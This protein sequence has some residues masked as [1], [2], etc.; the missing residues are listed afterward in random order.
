MR[1]WWA[2][3]LWWVLG[4]VCWAAGGSPPVG[5]SAV[6]PD[7]VAYR[8]RLPPGGTPVLPARDLLSA[9]ERAF[10]ATLPELR[11]GLNLPDNRPYEV[12][13]ADGEVSGVQVELLTHLAQSLGLRLRPV[14][15]PS[16]PAALAALR[17]RQV[18]LM[19]TLGYEP[20]R[21][22]YLRYTLGTAPNPGAVIGRA[23]DARL[24]TDPDLNQ[25]R[26]AI[27]RGY[28]ARHHVQRVWPEAVIV[29][30]PDTAAALRAVASGQAD[31]YVGSLLMAMDRI[32][33]DAVAG[34]EVKKSLIYATGLMHFGV[35]QD[36][37]LLASALS[38][39]IAALRA[40]PLPGQQ[41]ASQVLQGQSAASPRL[42]ALDADEQRLLARWPVLRVGAVRDLPLLNEATAGGGHAGVASD[43]THQVLAR[44]GAAAQVVP[45]DSVADLLDALRQGR[46]HLAPLLNRTPERARRLAFSVPYLDMPYYIVARTDAPLYWNLDSLRGRRLALAPQHPLRELLARQYAD[47]QIVDAAPGQGAM[48]LVQQGQADAAVEV[49]LFANLRINSGTGGVLRT[50]AH[51]DEMSAQFH[52][53][54]AP[55][56]AGLV[57]LIDRALLDI[58]QDE[59]ARIL[60]RWVAVDVAPTLAWRRHMPLIM[61]AGAALLLLAGGSVWWMRRL[62]A[63]V[64]TRRQVEER[65]SELARSLPG[66]VFQYVNAPDG[67]LE[68]RYVSPTVDEFLGP[69]LATAPSLFEAVSERLDPADATAL[70]DARQA[71]ITQHQPVKLTLRYADPRHGPR[72]LHC[73]AAVRRLAEGRVGW[74]GYIV[75][76]S[77]ERA[78]QAQLLD[79]VQTKNLFVASASHELRGPLQVITLALQRLAQGP[80]PPEQQGLCRIAQ[81]SSNALVQLIDDLLDLAQLEAGRMV[82]HPA[83]VELPALLQQLVDNHRLSAEP[84]GL[85]LL[86]RLPPG[87]P[88]PLMLD[89]LRLRQLLVNLI[90][91]AIKYTRQGEVRVEVFLRGGPA[92]D[93]GPGAEADTRR[94]P[95]L[96]FEVSDTGIG[97]APERLPRL[98]E[99]FSTAHGPQQAA[100]QRSTGLGLLICRQLCDAMGGRLLLRSAPG[101]GT[102]VTVDLP[103]PPLAPR[104][105][106]GPA[107]AALQ[108]GAG[109]PASTGAAASPGQDGLDGPA[110]TPPTCTGRVLLVDDDA[111]SRLLMGESLRRAGFQVR[112]ASGAA[113]ALACWRA[114]PV[115]L[116]L[117][118]HQMPGGD[119]LGL[120]RRIADDAVATG[121]ARPCLVLCSGSLV[122]LDA[123]TAGLDAVLR[124]PIHG[125]ALAQRLADVLAA[126]APTP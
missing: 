97:I 19:P 110:S 117:S 68:Q 45:F 92:G 106:P 29:D 76:V 57:P 77:S 54:A 14:V 28:V 79:A 89:A 33:R 99:P 84:R 2:C 42:L 35:R 67:Q 103:M 80:L 31:A 91:N 18:D 53:A 73:E 4:S 90:T 8:F 13:S 23:G 12:I 120:L 16:F 71:S 43:Y 105:G 63:E 55:A 78:L 115:D 6:A 81:D 47:I 82:L 10:L 40:A 124:K 27:E 22:A 94:G 65:L 48:D 11:V 26:V 100:D 74:T 98:F 58:P 50:V 17:E 88:S 96:V 72:W 85:R 41:Q 119:G 116:V 30:Q 114:Q 60:R 121:R 24:G 104:P 25:R 21:E 46:I 111:V 15:L 126:A 86:L 39:G 7:A 38:K 5:K 44:L 123:Q 3:A 52:F 59:R 107:H 101:Q 83:P 108:T 66:V 32:Q 118:D 36:W 93:D 109:A 122:D 61:L 125:S 64:R 51:V 9:E 70:R 112:E 1:V 95:R 49:K 102:Q 20:S 75:D 62:S 69:G 34:L 56:L 113:E 87:L 37:P